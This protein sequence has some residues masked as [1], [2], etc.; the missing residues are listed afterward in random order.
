MDVS[1]EGQLWAD[2]GSTQSHSGSCSLPGPGPGAP[3]CLHGAG[4]LGPQGQEGKPGQRKD[5]GKPCWRISRASKITSRAGGH[6]DR[7]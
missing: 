1:I 7:G 2:V 3:I 4:V 5:R 6:L